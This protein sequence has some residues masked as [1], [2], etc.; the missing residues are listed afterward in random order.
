MRLSSRERERAR[1]PVLRVEPGADDVGPTVRDDARD[2][3][4][5][6]LGELYEAAD[7]TGAVRWVA[8]DWEALLP[9]N[10][11]DANRVFSMSYNV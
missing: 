2:A 5:V 7:L 8:S 9:G 10:A 1:R 4:A 3:A 11:Y 6:D